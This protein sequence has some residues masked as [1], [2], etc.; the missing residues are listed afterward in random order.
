MNTPKNEI[1]IP[2]DLGRRNFLNKTAVAS[3]AGA[4]MSLGLVACNKS[5]G[6]AATGGPAVAAP[7]ASKTGAVDYSAYEVHPGQLDTYYSFSS[8]GHSGEVRIYGLPSGREDRKS[9]V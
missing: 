1:A 2:K 9:V 4:G 5:S 3:L 6:P 7:E 8:G